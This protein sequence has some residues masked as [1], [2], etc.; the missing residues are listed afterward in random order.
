MNSKTKKIESDY[1]KYIAM[2]RY[3][4]YQDGLD[5]RET[6][7]ETVTRLCDFWQKRYPDLFPYETIKNGV[8]NMEEMP[9]MRSLMTAGKALERDQV[10][11]YNC[12]FLPINDPRCFDEAMYILMC[13]HPDTEIVTKSGNKK[14][15]DLQIGDTVLSFSENEK[16]FTWEEVLNVIQNDVS[17][18]TKLELTFEDGT[19]ICCTHDHQWLTQNGWIKA[20]DL[21]EMHDIITPKFWIYK[22][23]NQETGKSYIGYTSKSIQERMNE[24][25]RDSKRYNHHFAKALSKY[26]ACVWKIEAIDFAFSQ[27]EAV[28]KEMKYISL[29]ETKKTGYNSTDGG[30]GTFGYSWTEE[31]KL[32]AS[33]NAYERTDAHREAQK[34]IIQSNFDKITASRQTIEYK[35]A[36]RERNLGSKNPAYGRKHS[37]EHKKQLSENMKGDKNPF[38]G[39]TH[40]LESKEKIKQSIKARRKSV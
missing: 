19:K 8:F 25:L 34:K 31:Q 20:E 21:T 1:S 3:A 7:E 30:E 10:A 37:E 4:R 15:R 40:S 6:W 5:R 14:I 35:K 2:S 36:Q 23:Q 13:F 39:K 12:S 33:E 28:K 18:K 24:H 22:I 27:E 16:T 17:A 26:S 11:G 32:K 29:F 38:F 9:S